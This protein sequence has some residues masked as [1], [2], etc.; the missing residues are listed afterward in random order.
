M[1][2]RASDMN[3]GLAEPVLDVDDIQGNILA[4]FRKDQQVLVAIQFRKLPSARKWLRRLWPEI[5]SMSEVLRFNELYRVQ[6]ARLGRDP[7]G[8]VSTW[9]NV[10]FSYPAVKALAEEAAADRLPSGTDQPFQLGMP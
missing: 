6:R 5:A 8:L 3:P 4:G 9:V 2:G 7:G 10:A 1:P